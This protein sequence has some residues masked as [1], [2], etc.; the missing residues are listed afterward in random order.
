MFAT[1]AISLFLKRAPGTPYCDDCLSVI[2]GIHPRLVPAY[3]S[4]LAQ[5]PFFDRPSDHCVACG[6][7]EA[8]LVIQCVKAERQICLA[9][10]NEVKS[11][12]SA[13]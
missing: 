8:K 9:V 6:S 4:R 2:L 7:G 13:R 5:R 10:D 3:T 1:E 12:F 11:T